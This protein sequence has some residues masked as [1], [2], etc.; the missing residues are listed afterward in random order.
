MRDDPNASGPM[1]TWDHVEVMPHAFQV[2]TSLRSEWLVALAT[3]AVDSDET[4]IRTVLRR[5]NLDTLVDK[6]YCFRGIGYKKPSNEFFQYILN[7]LKLD[8]NQIIM[9][10]DAFDKDVLGANQAGIRAIWLNTQ[11]TESRTGSLYRTIHDLEELPIALGAT[12]ISAK[13]SSPRR[14]SKTN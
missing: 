13:C 14:K 9:I 3:N 11:T 10:G 5:V 12:F 6:V 4:D 2:L 7:D 1:F 8:C